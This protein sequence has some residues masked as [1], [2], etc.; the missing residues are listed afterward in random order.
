MSERIP[1]FKQET[2]RDMVEAAESAIQNENFVM[3]ESVHKFEEEFAKYIG[4]RFAISVNSGS[5][6]LYLSLVSL[7]ISNNSKVITS[8]NSFIASSN[9]ILT[10]GAKPILCDIN[11]FDGNININSLNEKSDA[12]IPVHIY[13]NPCNY[14][15]IKEISE[16]GKI[17]VVEDACQAHGAKYSD[18]K[19]G[20]LGDT[21]CFSF[22]PTKNMTVGGDGGMVTTNNEEIAEKIAS[23]RD[24]G[25]KSKTEHDKLGHTMRL[26]TVNAAIGRV[27]LK[28][29]DKMNNRRREIASTYKKILGEENFLMEDSKNFAVYHQ[30]VFKHENREKIIKHLESNGIGYGIHYPIP[31]HKQPLYAHNNFHLPQSEKFCTQI[32]SL[33]SYPSLTNEEVN[34]IAEKILELR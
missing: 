8:T 11:N 31:I 16:E 32:L 1:F 29:L 21:G 9:C 7:G 13:G 23:L 17:P 18:K 6:A 14:D 28:Q 22:Y 30:I 2:T 34:F 10:V 15:S 4:T 33:P 27:Q 12:I 19:V 24:N 20:S 25:R 5:S 26:N 3:G